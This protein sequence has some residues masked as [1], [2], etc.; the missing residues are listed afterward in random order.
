MENTAL[1]SSSHGGLDSCG[2]AAAGSVTGAVVGCTAGV[3]GAVVLGVGEGPRGAGSGAAAGAGPVEC[4]S[5][6]ARLGP[7][8]SPWPDEGIG[9]AAQ[10]VLV[11]VSQDGFD[12]S[13]LT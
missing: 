3:G 10:A 1:L 5:T 2:A 7:T 4:C 13:G 12:S 9:P 8:D 6:G 11:S